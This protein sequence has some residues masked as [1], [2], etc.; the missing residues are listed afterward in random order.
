MKII[1]TIILLLAFLPDANGQDGSDIRYFKTSQVDKALIGHYVHFDFHNRSFTSRRIDTVII[2]I[3]NKHIRFLE[4]R[5]DNGF[6][7]WFSQQYLQSLDQVNNQTIRIT[8]FK[9]DGIKPTSFMVTMY[10]DFYDVQ[11][12]PLNSKPKEIKYQFDKKDIVEVL[13][14][15]KHL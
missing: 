11:N 13:V 12:K 6:N 3:D 10:V 8:H 5:K 1:K 14:K 4:I 7:N 2:T 15:A 9:I